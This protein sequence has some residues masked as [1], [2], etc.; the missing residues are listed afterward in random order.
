MATFKYHLHKKVNGQLLVSTAECG[1][2][3][4]TKNGAPNVMFKTAAFKTTYESDNNSCC[5]VC[6]ERAKQQNRI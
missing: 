3:L 6:V 2:G 1:R 4:F 5:S